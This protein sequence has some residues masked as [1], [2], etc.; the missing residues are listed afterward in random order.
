MAEKMN[1][2]IM[3]K[4]RS[5]LSNSYLGGVFW[6]EATNYAYYLTNRS[7][8]TSI[9]KKTPIEVW[10]GNPG[11]YSNIRVFGC[12]ANAHVDNGKLEPRAFK[13]LFLGFKDGVKDF[14]IWYPASKNVVISRSVVFN[15][16][17]M[18]RDTPTQEAP[19]IEDLETSEFEVE[20][21]E[22][23]ARPSQ[24]T[25][26]Q[27]KTQEDFVDAIVD[28]PSDNVVAYNESESDDNDIEVAPQHSIAYDRARRVI[29]KPRRFV[30]EANHVALALSCAEE[31]EGYLEP[32]SYA[33]AIESSDKD[34][35]PANVLTKSVSANMFELCSNLVG[36][37]SN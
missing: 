33:E 17:S 19:N 34:K 5:M 14:K 12:L 27:V 30:E 11:S 18:I 28:P 10:S 37:T 7:P 23:S 31:V 26:N 35:N 4:A 1:M 13:C 3:E 21:V 2:T 25:Q 6:A 29:H 22:L 20:L 8:N 16:I 15:E 36:L 32:S 24:K 9:E